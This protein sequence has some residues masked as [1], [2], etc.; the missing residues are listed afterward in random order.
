MS[1][2]SLNP[3]IV[4]IVFNVQKEADLAKINA[5]TNGQDI[6]VK[7]KNQIIENSI[8]YKFYTPQGDYD[9]TNGLQNTY[10]TVT[11]N[12]NNETYDL[13]PRFQTKYYLSSIS[14]NSDGL[15]LR[16]LGTISTQRASYTPDNSRASIILDNA[17]MNSK[18]ENKTFEIPSSQKDVRATLTIN[19]INSRKIKLTLNGNT[20]RDY[21]FVVS[22]DGQ[23][24]FVSHRT[25]IINTVFSPNTANISN[26]KYTKTSA[27]YNVFEINFDKAVTYDV[28]EMNDN[29]YLDINNLADFNEILFKQAFLDNNI[30]I[31]AFKIAGDKTRYV[32]PMDVMNFSYAN[33]E[34]NSKS[35]KL[36]FKD[37]AIENPTVE[38]LPQPNQ[39]EIAKATESTKEEKKQQENI[40]DVKKE[41]KVEGETTSDNIN[42][43]YIP[44]SEEIKEEKEKPK[45]KKENLAISSL[46]RVVIDPGHGGIDSGAI[47]GG[48]YEN[49]PRSI[50]E[51]LCA[52][53]QRDSIKV[54]P[55]FNLIA[56]KGNIGER[57]M[58]NTFN[59][60][61]GMSVVVSEKDVDCALKILKANGEDAYVIGK[62]IK[63]E[64][65]IQIC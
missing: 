9:K 25:Y 16:G 4:R 53:I 65:K 34:S 64:D 10:A 5:Y 18:L 38:I 15:I 56:E 7:Y 24:L 48:F 62:I 41:N 49:I 54:L 47:G 44:K 37:K 6:V 61:V 58:F 40:V 39:N 28:F 59:M 51:G 36:C 52:Q 11:Y 17:S 55:I 57:E 43:V 46:K 21:R 22:P 8:Q 1:Q 3:N 35:I 14:Q 13:T 32:V 27:N 29:F 60:G 50:P 12:A 20:L 45:K 19:R 42:V 30:K 23:S 31:Q 33:I 2:F 26:Y 63:S